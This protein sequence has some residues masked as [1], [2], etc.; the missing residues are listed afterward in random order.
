METQMNLPPIIGYCRA[1]EKIFYPCM[2]WEF[3]TLD[4]RALSDMNVI[5]K[6]GY[7][8]SHNGFMSLLTTRL[9]DVKNSFN[10]HVVRPYQPKKID[11]SL[12]Q[13]CRIRTQEIIDRNQP[14]VIFWSGGIDSTLLLCFLFDQLKNFDQLKIYYTPDSVREN[15]EFV[16][17]IKKF[18]VEMVRWDTEYNILF[19]QD[20]LIVTGDHGDCISGYI[21][22]D[23]YNLNKEWLLRPWQ[24]FFQFKG[25]DPNHITRIE[26]II[27]QQNIGNIVNLI[28][29]N[30]W[31]HM[32]VTYQYWTVR[33]WT[34]NLENV[35]VDNNLGF[36]DCDI[37]NQW[38]LTNRN[39]LSQHPSQTNYKQCYRDEIAKFWPNSNYVANKPKVKSLQGLAWA[40]IKMLQHRQNFLFLY[41]QNGEI[42]SYMPAHH[43]SLDRAEILEDLAGMQ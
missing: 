12:H 22:Q 36:F 13:A 18:G 42:K 39:V 9:P 17:Y 3:H 25:L 38:S 28:D 5:L 40:E 20:Q 8:D 41:W 23:F 16:D 11:I 34:F 37:M 33:S 32:Y 29:L 14:I 24:D 7:D 21:E 6:G 26:H 30:W 31:F 10:T 2:G 4:S 27:D 19:N 1:F 35:S 43:L 15:P